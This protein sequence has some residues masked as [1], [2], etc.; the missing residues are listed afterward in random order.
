LGVQQRAIVPVS[1]PRL[2]VGFRELEAGAALGLAL[3]QADDVGVDVG[4]GVAVGA[5][6]GVG[7]A[8]GAGV[9]VGVGAGVAVGAGVGV[10]GGGPVRF[11]GDADGAGVGV[12]TGVAVSVGVGPHCTTT[13]VIVEVWPFTS[14]RVTVVFPTPTAA[15]SNHDSGRSRSFELPWFRARSGAIVTMCSLA[16]VA[17]T[18]RPSSPTPSMIPT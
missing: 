3:G 9:G 4:V 8:V 11:G 6:V 2:P 12:G 16:E 14:R 7:V 17:E 10:A 1:L 15:T 13:T 5:G 18:T